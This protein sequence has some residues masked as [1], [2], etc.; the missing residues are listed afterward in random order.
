MMELAIVD[1]K[2]NKALGRTDLSCAVSFEKAMPSRK[3]LRE[4]IVAA[5]GGDPSLLVIVSAKSGFGTQKAIVTA[6]AYGSKEAMAV[7]R[8]YLLVRDGLAEK[9]KKEAKKAAAPAKK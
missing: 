9:K 4:A 5:I 6:H 1:K 3:E 7:E 2:E 8:R